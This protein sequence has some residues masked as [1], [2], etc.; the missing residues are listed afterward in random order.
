[1]MRKCLKEFAR[2]SKRWLFFVELWSVKPIIL[3][4]GGNLLPPA[5][6][7][8]WRDIVPPMLPGWDVRYSEVHD[9]QLSEADDASNLAMLLLERR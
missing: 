8:P 6:A 5:W 2:V 7:Y 4:F 3:V 9:N 1:M